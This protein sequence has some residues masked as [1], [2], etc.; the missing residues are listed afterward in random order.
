[1]PL[2]YAKRAT[3]GQGHAF[4]GARHRAFFFLCF[5]LFPKTLESSLIFT[6]FPIPSTEYSQAHE[7][8]RAVASRSLVG[9]GVFAGSLAVT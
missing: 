6:L 2:A 3:A 1:M 4:G 5:T 7:P 9:I 8:S